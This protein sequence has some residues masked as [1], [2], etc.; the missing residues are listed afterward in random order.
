MRTVVVELT[1]RVPDNET[2]D[3]MEQEINDAAHALPYGLV[4]IEFGNPDAR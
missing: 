3:Q 4:D 2:E 1:L